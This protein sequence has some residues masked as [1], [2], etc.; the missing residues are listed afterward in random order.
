MDQWIE[1][2]AGDM[3]TMA[4]NAFMFRRTL[5]KDWG[6]LCTPHGFH[7]PLAPDTKMECWATSTDRVDWYCP[8]MTM[9]EFDSLEQDMVGDNPEPATE[10]PTNVDVPHVQ[11]DSDTLTCT[12]GNWTGEPTEY[13]YVWNI[14]GTDIP[15]DTA[16]YVIDSSVVGL[17]AY[18][19]VTAVNAIGTTEA[20]PSN[21]LTIGEPV[22]TR[23]R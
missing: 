16:S 6:Y 5:T 14:D 8:S 15:A 10:A 23:R 17:T 12:M 19:V 2:Q 13:H 22:A 21:E 9:A 1:V 11:Q 7:Q 3:Q 18:C 4:E 20:P